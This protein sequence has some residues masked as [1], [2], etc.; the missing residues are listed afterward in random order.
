MTESFS[1]I[2]IRLKRFSC[3]FTTVVVLIKTSPANGI[4]E[5][6]VFPGNAI[7]HF[8]NGIKHSQIHLK[9]SEKYD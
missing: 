4:N 5:F 3:L 7:L 8:L 2:L 9:V 6:P 1:K